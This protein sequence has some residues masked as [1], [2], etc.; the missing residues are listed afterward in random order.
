MFF[1]GIDIAKRNHEAAIVDDQGRIVQKAFGFQNSCDGFNKLLS[2]VLRITN[3]KSQ[4]V[5]G[6]ESTSHY[7]LALYTR[8]MKDGYQVHVFN[9]M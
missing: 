8:L 2:H 4:V 9:P 3:A 1:V 6:M 7:W 5:V